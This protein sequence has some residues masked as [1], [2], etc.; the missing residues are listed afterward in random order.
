MAKAPGKPHTARDLAELLTV[1]EATLAK[2]LQRLVK[3]GVIS[4]TR[5]PKGGFVMTKDPKNITLLEVYEAIEGRLTPTQC[6]LSKPV[7]GGECLLQALLKD[8]DVKARQFL[9]E[10]NLGDVAAALPDDADIS[11]IVNAG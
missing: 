2:A 6:L 11:E 1:S 3:A 5:G 9:A 10:K 4:S 8:V 7:C